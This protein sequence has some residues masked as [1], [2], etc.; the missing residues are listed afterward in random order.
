MTGASGLIVLECSCRQWFTG[1][2][3]SRGFD[4]GSPPQNGPYK[5]KPYRVAK[6]SCMFVIDAEVVVLRILKVN[7]LSIAMTQWSKLKGLPNRAMEHLYMFVIDTGVAILRKYGVGGTLWCK[8]TTL[9]VAVQGASSRLLH[10]QVEISSSSKRLNNSLF[11]CGRNGCNKIY[12]RLQ[13][14]A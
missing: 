6:R 7:S 13:W 3:S 2:Y 14:C 12:Y 1:A 5:C 4:G 9:I 8:V 10:V 11:C